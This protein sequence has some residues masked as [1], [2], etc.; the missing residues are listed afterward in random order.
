MTVIRKGSVETVRHES[1]Y[2]APHTLPGHL[3]W[4]PLSDAGGLTQF[5]AAHETLLPGTQSSLMHWESDEDEFLYMLEGRLTVIEDGAQTEIGPGDACAWKA[6]VAVGHCLR[7]D[8]DAPARYLIVG[9]R[10]RETNVATYP[11][12]D[13]LATPEGFTRL[14]GTPYPKKDTSS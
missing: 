10:R 6:G 13:L 12:L 3:E 5:G 8:S 9:S 14:D 2:P 4:E 11:G 1:R 7:N